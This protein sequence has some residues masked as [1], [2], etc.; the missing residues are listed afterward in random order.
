MKINKVLEVLDK[1]LEDKDLTIWL[2]AEQI[3]KLKKE[4]E[5]LRGKTNEQDN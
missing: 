3:K 5:N 1:A 4:I 2:Q